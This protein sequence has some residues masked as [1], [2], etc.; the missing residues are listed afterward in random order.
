MICII[1]ALFMLIDW[2]QGSLTGDVWATTVNCIGLLMCILMGSQLSWKDC[3]K[4]AFGIWGLVWLA[5]SA[6]GFV[7]WKMNP[8]HVL[9]GQFIT[10]ALNIGGIGALVL[11][12]WQ[13]GILQ[14]Y[15]KSGKW[16][17]CY[18]GWIWAAMTLW[19]CLSPRRS[20]WHLCFFAIFSLFYLLP[21]NEEQKG[22]VA[23]GA[24]SGIVVGFFALQILAYG[25]RPYDEV[26]YKGMYANCN[27]NALMYLVTYIAILTLILMM[28]RKARSRKRTLWLVFYY[29]LAGGLLGFQLMTMTRTAL[30]LDVAVTVCFLGVKFVQDIRD[31]KRTLRM[32]G[33]VAG[34][35]LLLGA[36]C[37][38]L[39]PAVFGTVRYL[40]AILHRPVWYAYEYSIERVHSFD[41]WNSY[42][43]VE[44]DEFLETFCK[45][46]SIALPIDFGKDAGKALETVSVSEEAVS[47]EAILEEAVSEATPGTDMGEEAAET[48][49]AE[50]VSESVAEE[51]ED[52][53]GAG[54]SAQIRLKIY[55]LYLKN[56][57]LTGHTTEEGFYEITKSYSAY[58]AHNVFLQMLFS[59]GIPAGI[60]LILL[61]AGLGIRLLVAF[62]RNPQDGWTIFRGLVYLVFFG[63]GM[64][65]MTWNTGQIIMLLLFVTQKS[66]ETE[67]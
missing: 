16:K 11:R 17:K 51:V 50:T 31:R 52:P 4:K 49:T 55:E 37:V 61:T 14:D 39:F 34:R 35:G 59:Y 1:F 54:E 38:L 40:P 18:L 25:F 8:E 53:T 67:A 66:L 58:H 62:I 20:L 32:I 42:K 27:N 9:E 45:R 29:V 44:F 24:L 57:N 2:S 30:I 10:A 22:K 41:P 56:L 28:L 19:M 65:E 15:V 47:G 64:L 60:L 43:Y 13:C 7:I 26:R 63:Y 5:G 23:R 21:L 36:L 12:Y 3:K 6:L 48:L 46:F 33:G